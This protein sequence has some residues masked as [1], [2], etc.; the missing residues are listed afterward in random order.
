MPVCLSVFFR[1]LIDII[2]PSRPLPESNL[3]TLRDILASI[4][5]KKENSVKGRY[6][7]T[8][9]MIDDLLKDIKKVYSNAHPK[10]VFGLVLIPETSVKRKILTEWNSLGTLSKS[11]NSKKVTKYKEKLDKIF[12]MFKC[13]CQMQSCKE[14]KC[15][16]SCKKIVHIKCKCDNLCKIPESELRFAYDERAKVGSKGSFQ[17]G[18][19][20]QIDAKKH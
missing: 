3:P 6:E 11:H 15:E 7:D 5:L 10:F 17:I 9:A 4:L 12:E 16:T 18:S 14:N 13:K 19:D 20:D 1:L 8:K 2:G